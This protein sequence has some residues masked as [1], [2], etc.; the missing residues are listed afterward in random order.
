MGWKDGV[1]QRRGG[2]ATGGSDRNLEISLPHHQLRLHIPLP[3]GGRE[4]TPSSVPA[5]DRIP[6]PQRYKGSGP[7]EGRV[8][9]HPRRQRKFVIVRGGRARVGGRI[10]PG[11]GE[12]RT[13][14]RNG[15][16]IKPTSSA[17]AKRPVEHVCNG[18]GIASAVQATCSLVR[19]TCINN[20]N[21]ASRSCCRNE[22]EQDTERS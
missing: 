7:D 2:M 21:A 11:Q 15:R 3:R 16:T 5:K 13:Q 8:P 22:N 9:R 12:Q 4:E 1:I 14:T 17:Q 10:E 20:Y 6:H 18:A 19:H